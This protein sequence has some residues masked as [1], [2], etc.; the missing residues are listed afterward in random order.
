MIAGKANIY[1]YTFILTFEF[2]Y[3]LF[4]FDTKWPDINIQYVQ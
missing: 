2:A 1:P 3:I 4:E